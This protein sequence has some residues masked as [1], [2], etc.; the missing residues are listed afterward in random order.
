MA[1][2]DKNKSDIAGIQTEMKDGFTRIDFE[3]ILIKD[4]HEK[5]FK[6]LRAGFKDLKEDL[7]ELKENLNSNLQALTNEVRSN[8]QQQMTITHIMLQMINEKK[9]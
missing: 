8:N 6:D 9:K 1:A 5:D 7:K 4:S 3:L 2:V